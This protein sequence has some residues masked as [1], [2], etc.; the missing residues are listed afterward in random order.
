MKSVILY[1]VLFFIAFS[2]SQAQEDK[3]SFK[4]QYTI[5]SP[6]KLS[7]SVSDGDININP[8]NDGKIE[9]RY[10]VYKNNNFINIS[11]EE[12]NEYVIIEVK[13]SENMLDISIRQRN[14]VNWKKQ[15]EVS[16]EVYTPAAT[17]CN[18]KSSDGDILISGLNAD[19]K[20]ITSDGDI[21]VIKNNGKVDLHTSDGDIA[22]S[23]ITGD[24]EL[25]TSDGDIEVENVEGSA[26]LITSDGDIS[27][28]NATG[29]ISAKTSDGDIIARDC[30]G[31]I[32][33]S[34][35][36]GDIRCN[37]LKITNEI[38]LS[39]SDGD[40]NITIPKGLSLNL[41]VKGETLRV[42]LVN[43][44]GKTEEYHIEGTINGGGIPVELIT[45]DGTIT[46]SYL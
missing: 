39:T 4:E 28:K 9:V 22:I 44:S 24:I 34:T 21:V 12:L 30:N 10:F 11:K 35:S 33:A 41:K 26:R 38:S 7:I 25:E 19:Q 36:D 2:N 5:S 16:L 45:T 27:L 29:S 40:I 3:F 20:C 15:Y 17:S 8:G 1:F 37:L 13:H 42:P 6:T 18:L 23:E 14:Q 46:L 31:S 43:F 32:T